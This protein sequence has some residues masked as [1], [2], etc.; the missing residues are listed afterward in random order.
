VDR[1]RLARTPEE[2][3]TTLDYLKETDSTRWSCSIALSMIGPVYSSVGRADAV[4]EK[5][6]KQ[7]WGDRVSN[8]KEICKIR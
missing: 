5:E 8:L 6:Y 7:Q 3:A 2:Q 4:P 1:T